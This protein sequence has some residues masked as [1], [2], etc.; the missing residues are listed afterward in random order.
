MPRRPGPESKAGFVRAQPTTISAAA[1]VSKAKASGIKL[2]E[3]YV[4]S[5]RTAMNK[6]AKKVGGSASKRGPGRP[7]KVSPMN[8]WRRQRARRRD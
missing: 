5:V 4:Y 1:V 8:G 2:D 7:R 3:R 6:K